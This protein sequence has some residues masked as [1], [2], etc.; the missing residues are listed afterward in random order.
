[1]VVSMGV[2]I[3]GLALWT[4]WRAPDALAPLVKDA[5]ARTLWLTPALGGM[6]LLVALVE[7]ALP[8]ET[9]R[10]W[11]NGPDSLGGLGLAWLAGVLTPGGPIVGLPLT[12]ALAATGVGPGVLVTYLTSLSLL[13]LTRLPIEA[14]VLG[15]R[16]TV[17]R[18]LACAILPI[19]A[20]LLA[21]GRVGP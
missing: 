5:L 9:L 1:M 11:L 6:L 13:N 7:R 4:A 10:G 3:G 15:A 21:R 8:T 16:L 19:L 2:L 14:G 20:G 12:A 18:L 17:T